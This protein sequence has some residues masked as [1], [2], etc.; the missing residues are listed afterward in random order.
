MGKNKNKTSKYPF[1]SI[2]TPT[3]NR[4][5]FIPIIIKCFENQ[6]YPRD[7]M[8]W[9]IVDDG[10]DKIEDLVGHLPYVRYFKYD[11][12]MTLGKKRNI[13]NE[14]AKGDIIVYMDDDDYYPPERVKHA[15]ERLQES[16]ALCAGSS[17][18]FLYFKH[19]NKMF[20]FGPYGP[21][22]AT[23]A[24]F[25]FKRE[26][27]Q[28]TKFEE[29]SCV[30]EEKKFLKDYTI[31]FVQLD[32]TKS[33]LVF[34][35]NHNSFDKK[36][37]LKQLP[38]PTI[39]ETPLLPKDLVS[40]PDILKFFMEDIDQLLENYDPGRPEHKPDVKKQLAEL[41]IEREK[42]MQEM[43]KQ[44]SEYKDTINK[45]NMISNPQIVQK[46]INEQSMIIQQL[47]FENNQLKEQVQ[48]LNNKI[49]QLIVE[50][51]EKRKDI[52]RIELSSD[53]PKINIV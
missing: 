13:S 27:L 52:Q 44:Q 53:I 26:L 30:A 9:V 3:F 15:V 1:V 33:I 17:A 40:E 25:A 51:I 36:E 6:T 20:Q 23:A 39:H 18:M 48:Y 37:L 24:T 2:C 21:N 49:K 28:K 47:M 22:H 45:I 12:K 32:S 16:K 7:K 46:Q 8:E 31:P 34:S 50:Q 14:K 41:K 5:P 43:M 29:D 35:H 42:K 11:E 19:I 10:S 38:N 4:R